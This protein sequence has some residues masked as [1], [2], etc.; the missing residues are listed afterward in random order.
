M[1][2]AKSIDTDLPSSG[3]GLV[4]SATH[5]PFSDRRFWLSQLMV[6]SVFLIHLADDI[7]SNHGSTLIPDFVWALL[8]LIPVIYA[9]SAFGLVGSLCTVLVGIVALAPAELLF[10]HTATEL[11]AA[12]SVY[13]LVLIIAVIVGDRFEK[14]R[15]TSEAK[16]V[17]DVLTE[18]EE[19]FRL[20]FD[21]NMSPMAIANLDGR[22]IRVNRAYCVMLGRSGDD[23]IGHS[24][25]EYTHPD[26]LPLTEEALQKMVSGE[27][28]QLRYSKQ[29]LHRDASVVYAEVSIT[30]AKNQAGLPAY[31][32]ASVRNTTAEKAAAKEMEDSERRFRL[33]FENNSAGMV[34]H[35]G[36][37][38]FVIANQTFCQMV[39][40]TNEEMAEKG[41]S[42]FIHPLDRE[43][44]AFHRK[45]LLSGEQLRTRDVRRYLHR[46]GNEVQ[47]EVSRSV[48]FGEDAKPSFFITSLRDITE[49]RALATE[50]SHLALHDPLTGLPNRVLLQDRMA[51]AHERSSRE[52]KGIA[53]FLLDL[54]DFKGVNDTL[55]HH[56]GDRLLI[57]VSKRLEEVARSSDT[58]CRFG[59]DEFVYLAEGLS[60]P[61]DAETIAGRLLAIFEEPFVFDGISISQGASVGAVICMSADATDCTKLVQ[62]ADTAM[63]EAKRLGK[64][65]HVVFAPEMSEKTSGRFKLVQ[66]LGHALSHDEISMH[67]QPIVELCTGEIVGYEA[68]MR[69]K[70]PDGRWIS[71]E[72]FI[73]IAE[74]SDLILKLGSFALSKAVESASTWP[75]TQ[76]NTCPPYVAINLS[77]R[78]FHDQN[79]IEMVKEV[80]YANGFPAGRLVLE[81]TESVALI[82][83]D[84]TIRTIS[85]LKN[86]GASVALD[87]FGTG[88]SSLSY[89]AKLRPNIIKIDRSFV[90]SAQTSPDARRLL[91]AMVSLCHVLN[92]TVIAEGIETRDQL[93]MVTGLKCEYGQ[94]FI[95]SKAVSADLLPAVHGLA[96]SWRAELI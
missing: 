91:E 4:R 90:S 20:A 24:L 59:G 56:I 28:D 18:S 42:L 86:L 84:S 96:S 81:I 37:G 73:P 41:S 47:V 68:L 5:P 71:P 21:G 61:E 55:G 60:T 22:L 94:G 17:A 40:Y 45:R 53:V 13:F 44:A 3:S 6:L 49:E 70:T 19:R 95:F 32:I 78:Q 88:Y 69:W 52:G 58:L 66:D 34:L 25:L 27:V 57:A 48:A 23:L 62:D 87:D 89:L 15:R 12:W 29:F 8:L 67:Y 39:G 63:Y 72:I 74:D 65:R 30:L 54:D 26:D 77:A 16:A 31:V 43:A 1:N 76:P 9:G 50:L 46:D 82:D 64:A 11:W 85:E 38:T 75:G 83:I 80:L 35:D 92:M 2:E 10:H 7:I 51:S 36:N 93:A 79:L 14:I 33:A